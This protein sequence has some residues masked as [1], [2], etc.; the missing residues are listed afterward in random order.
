MAFPGLDSAALRDCTDRNGRALPHGR[1]EA[2]IDPG[3]V[4]ERRSG[5]PQ[6]ERSVR[7]QSRSWA[8]RAGACGE[9]MNT[10]S[11]VALMAVNRGLPR[12]AS[13]WI[14]AAMKLTGAGRALFHSGSPQ[15][16]KRR[17]ISSLP[18]PLAVGELD[19][20]LLK[21]KLTGA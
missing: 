21:C 14:V 18:S 3:G 11:K 7:L 10:I 19:S 9:A 17:H 1:I 15:Y 4:I 8:T 13:M 6:E 5:A 2:L 20:C 12:A 16:R